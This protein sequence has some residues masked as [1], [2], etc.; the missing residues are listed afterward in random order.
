MI[1]ALTKLLS[2]TKM[3]QGLSENS[4][5]DLIL[6]SAIWMW[7]S[8]FTLNHWASTI[9]RSTWCH[10]GASATLERTTGWPHAIGKEF[11]SRCSITTRLST[12]QS[13]GTW[14]S[15]RSE[16]DWEASSIS[17]PLSTNNWRQKIPGATLVSWNSKHPTILRGKTGRI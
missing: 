3:R 17:S 5:M 9:C 15:R 12:W 10:S 2:M 8:D 6:N 4:N 14:W 13:T 16:I 1:Q 11:L 7:K